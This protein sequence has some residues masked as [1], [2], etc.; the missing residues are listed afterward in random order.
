MKTV[1]AV[2]SLLLL[3]SPA[4]AQQDTANPLL[5]GVYLP[6]APIPSVAAKARLVAD[7]AQWLSNGLGTTVRGRA[8]SNADEFERDLPHLAFALVDAAVAASVRG[9]HPLALAT[10]TGSDQT[11]LIVLATPSTPG[12]W[13][14]AGK[15]VAYPNLG[16]VTTPLLENVLFSGELPL[17]RLVRVPVADAASAL[18]SA[19]LGRADAA[20]VT[21]AA[22]D[23][24]G[25]GGEVRPILSSSELPLAVFCQGGAADAALAARARAAI[26]S[27]RS[28]DSGI[29]GFRAVTTGLESLRREL[30]GRSRQP[31]VR[32]PTPNFR[33]P[34]FNFPLPTLP[35]PPV[36]SYLAAIPPPPAPSLP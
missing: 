34:S 23:K 33:G 9:T 17:T 35:L 8:Y 3:A 2:L 6:N 36:R 31:E 7:L 18:A 12:P 19:R 29:D 1:A 14:L 4:R 32:D 21:E 27:F 22:F 30:A 5:V 11:R 15:R 25:A 16:R 26:V 24:L 10:H 13:A 20:I 28:Q